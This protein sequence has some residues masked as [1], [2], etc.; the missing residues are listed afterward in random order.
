MN[1]LLVI[2]FMVPFTLGCEDT[3]SPS[4]LERRNNEAI[5][6][7]GQYDYGPAAAIW[8]QLAA[9]AP[10]TTILQVNLA[11]AIL[12]RQLDGDEPK[13]LALL[14]N[15]LAQEPDN[16]RAAYVAGVLRL[17]NGNNAAAI[18]AFQRVLDTDSTD[19]YAWY[20][21][22]SA[23]EASDAAAAVEAYQHAVD[24]DPYLRSAWYR[25]GQVSARLDQPERASVALR[26]FER[27]E[28]NPRAV[29]I[30]PVYGRLGPK[31]L[32]AT[33]DQPALEPNRPKGPL[34][35][36]APVR[37][38]EPVDSIGAPSVAELNGDGERDIFFGG[39]V[40]LGSD[41]GFVA[42][43]EHPLAQIEGVRFALFG[44]LDNDG[45]VDA[46]LARNGANVVMS[47]DDD[48]WHDTTSERSL[49]GGD[50]LTLDGIL[51]D[52]DHDGDLDVILANSNGPTQLF[53]NTLN[54][55][56]KDISI[57]TGFAEA[58][59]ATQLVVADLD[60]SNDLD[61]LVLRTTG[62]NILFRND[63]LWS[64]T[65]EPAYQGLVHAV[66]ADL[67]GTGSTKVFGVRPDYTL[68][69]H[70]TV[71]RTLDGF[72][73]NLAAFDVDGD[74][75]LEL[76][77]DDDLPLENVRAWTPAVLNTPEEGYSIVAI[78]DF[79]TPVVL[80]PG[81]GR[82]A[83]APLTLAGAEDPTQQMRSNANGVGALV[84]ARRGDQ[85]TIQRNLP[86]H[87]GP[88]Q[89]LEPMVVGL[90]GAADLDFLLIDWPD[91]LMQT[92]LGAAAKGRIVETQRQASSCPVLFAFDGESMAFVSDVL[93]VGG[94]GFLL[95]PG[96]HSEP[97]PRERFLLPRGA[98]GDDHGV[99]SLV[100]CEPMEEAC[101]LDHVALQGWLLPDGWHMAIDERMAVA[102][103]QPT[104]DPLFFRASLNPILATN[105]RGNDVTQTI[106]VSDSVAAP[107]GPIDSR[108]IGR[109]ARH[110]SL[111]FTFD[112]SL[113]AF[114]DPWLLMD[115]WI[116]YPYSQTMFA[117]WQAGA[118]FDAPTLEARGG[119]GRWHVVAEQFGYPAGMPRTA[120]FQ[121]AQLPLDTR[122]LR[123][124]TNQEIYW[125]RLRVVAAEAAPS[126]AR[127][128]SAPLLKANLMRIGYPKRIEQSQ[129][130]PDYDYRRRA[131]MADFRH[132]RGL[133]SSFGDVAERVDT[134]DQRIAI[135][136]PGEG[137]EL[138]F[139][140]PPDTS[141][142]EVHWILDVAGWCKDRDRFTASGNTLEPLPAVAPFATRMESGH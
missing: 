32:A 38:S 61:V 84:A 13:A 133:Y 45:G 10:A 128:V 20:H 15:V 101:Y 116:E 14:N 115:G 129:R 83:F 106:L 41:N 3:R 64:F 113:D 34:W 141:A 11:I 82:F 66:A 121:L 110:H 25:L 96:E 65:A 100:L 119:D 114:D 43:P 47:R 95:A 93:G 33:L 49:D 142:E 72:P 105:D 135:F 68:V 91:G 12:N 103:P 67:D 51:V 127:R 22:G 139:S 26:E 77:T 27:L 28:T 52:I 126:G 1:R 78:Q 140:L 122:A 35:A 46:Y 111:E 16:V 42:A 88:G 134:H 39:H 53:A 19:A 136:G 131:P 21:L 44:D 24:L 97:R 62:A 132:L 94:I 137:I 37:L 40:F 125:D 107:V 86:T 138:T 90:S 130:R 54:G 108:F 4:S 31:A 73:A 74:G 104:G 79:G 23:Q 6:L 29:M 112:V 8:D 58:T 117:S 56:F 123:L 71:L 98:V 124:T 80:S 75:T 89:S 87:S 30:K 81:T 59:D 50:F 120:A 48:T 109:L 17:R 76:V 60:D 9:E 5:G 55:A 18:A 92:E 57:E 118:T 2:I 63:R 70:D 69:E 36:V 7:M 102:G 99:L 85:W